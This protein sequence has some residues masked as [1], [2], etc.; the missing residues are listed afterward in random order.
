MKLFRALKA[1]YRLARLVQKYPYRLDEVSWKFRTPWPAH[2]PDSGPWSICSAR[3]FLSVARS[4]E[5][6]I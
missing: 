4:F 2:R 6:V 5:N 1:I 3:G